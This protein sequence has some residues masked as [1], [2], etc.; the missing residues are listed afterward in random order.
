[1]RG[2]IRRLAALALVLVMT[3]QP[4]IAAGEIDFGSL[5][6][7]M[8]RCDGIFRDLDEFVDAVRSGDTS[9]LDMLEYPEAY[10]EMHGI[11][12]EVFGDMVINPDRFSETDRYY[13]AWTYINSTVE[14][15]SIVWDEELPMFS[16]PMLT[17]QGSSLDCELN[18]HVIMKALG[19]S[20]Y[21]DDVGD[22]YP[23]KVV[24]DG[25]NYYS[26]PHEW[27]K[28]LFLVNGND[29]PFELEAEFSA[30][31]PTV[32]YGNYA[33]ATEKEDGYVFIKGTGILIGYEGTDTELVF[34]DRTRVIKAGLFEGN[35]SIRKAVF[36][37]GLIDIGRRA[38]LGCT[39]LEEIELPDGLMSLGFA[40]FARSGVKEA[41]IP[42]SVVYGTCSFL[43]S[44][45]GRVT[46]AEGSGRV[47]EQMFDY[48]DNLS[49]VDIPTSVWHIGHRAFAYCTALKELDLSAHTCDLG[50]MAFSGAG[51]RSVKLPL[52]SALQMGVF[53]HCTSL[54]EVIMQEGLVTIDNSFTYCI[55]LGQVT[56]PASVVALSERAF[57]DTD[58]VIPRDLSFVCGEGSAAACYAETHG[59][60]YVTDEALEPYFK[61]IVQDGLNKNSINY[62]IDYA[63]RCAL[64]TSSIDSELDFSQDGTLVIP[65]LIRYNNTLYPVTEIA[66]GAL[67]SI[68]MTGVRLPFMLRTIGKE[69]FWGSHLEELDFS[70]CRFLT[71]I[72]EG[73]FAYNQ[74][75]ADIEWGEYLKTIGSEAFFG[76]FAL[77]EVSIDGGIETIGESAF[78]QSG[79]EKVWIGE[80][81]E[82]ICAGAF[83]NLEGDS[84]NGRCAV[85]FEGNAPEVDAD[86]VGGFDGMVML[87]RKDGA[88][89]FDDVGFE[90]YSTGVYTENGSV[91]LLDKI[92]FYSPE[93]SGQRYVYIE[94]FHQKKNE[95]YRALVAFYD[96]NGRMLACNVDYLY[97]ANAY[98][99]GSI[100]GRMDVPSNADCMEVF[101]VEY[102]DGSSEPVTCS[103]RY[104]ISRAMAQ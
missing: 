99:K 16:R 34:P 6:P 37:E 103:L 5:C 51:L 68:S 40:G 81:V 73:A 101:L 20:M 67:S 52:I 90:G 24:I 91:A 80:N 23:D 96:E 98:V 76:C 79:L 29:W 77:K 19:I 88:A 44:D 83:S 41:V 84:R 38:F 94:A 11:V 82:K 43:E 58:Y 66:E 61:P 8:G 62:R 85:Y 3:V 17:K 2:L 104:D 69:A 63:N 59:I 32:E 10:M 71:E 65:D 50:Q 75:L 15:N 42:A 27:E 28:E 33:P 7:C 46:L 86:G 47:Y 53:S 22:P 60:P 72:G 95:E 45:I 57:I 13:A 102:I 70:D 78:A 92:Q 89:G 14:E 48:C 35:E 87:L 30:T 100:Q 55:S 18:Q 25:K 97:S 54:E 21:C 56:V 49:E 1:M 12:T 74:S 39:A 64:L 4:V 93:E 26:R 9:E 31:A 36:N